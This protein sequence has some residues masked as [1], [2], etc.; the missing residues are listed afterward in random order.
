MKTKMKRQQ[1]IEALFPGRTVVSFQEDIPSGTAEF[2]VVTMYSRPEVTYELMTQV[3]E[4]FGG[5]KMMKLGDG[6]R[7]EGCE[8]CD[9][10]S[11]YGVRFALWD[12]DF[13]AC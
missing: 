4:V 11:A 6:R 1:K 9:H 7:E 8:T 2:E 3:A 5:T 12:I 10:G 13:D